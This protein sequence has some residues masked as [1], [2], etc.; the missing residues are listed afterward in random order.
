MSNDLVEV[1][2]TTPTTSSSFDLVDVESAKEFMDNYQ[3]VCKALLD[4]SDFQKITIMGKPT[5]F[6]KKSAWRKK[7][8]L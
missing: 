1:G 4:S 3:A 5:A 8:R 6:K 7:S 2:E